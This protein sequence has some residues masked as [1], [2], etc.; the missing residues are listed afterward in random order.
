MFVLPM[1]LALGFERPDLRR[2]AGVLLGALAMVLIAL[3][4]AGVTPVV[5]V[6]MILLALISPLSY[7]IEANYLAW[8]GP[9]GLHPFQIMFG[10]AAAGALIVWPLA[11]ATGQL[12]S[13]ARPWGPAEW[14]LLAA[15]VLNA[16]A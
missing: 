9:G 16:L 2:S 7:G 4:G 3:P 15:G 6:G 14:A 11:A 13:L 5:G 12:V 10:A 1:A 8:R